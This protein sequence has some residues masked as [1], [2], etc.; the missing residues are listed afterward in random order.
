MNAN[1]GFERNVKSKN[2]IIKKDFVNTCQQNDPTKTIEQCERLFNRLSGVERARNWA[3]HEGMFQEQIQYNFNPPGYDMRNGQMD[4]NRLKRAILLRG[5]RKTPNISKVG[6]TL[7]HALGLD[8]KNI[9]SESRYK[10][11]MSPL[12]QEVFRNPHLVTEIGEYLG[13]PP[14][15]DGGTRKKRNKRRNRRRNKSKKR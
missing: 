14:N 5:T 15:A 6:S 2:S 10:Q 3:I 9:Y 12:S 13:L 1:T 8:P 7:S 11:S 4:Y